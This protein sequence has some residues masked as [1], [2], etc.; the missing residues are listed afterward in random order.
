[1]GN[2]RTLFILY[3]LESA[4]SGL[5]IVFL[6]FSLGITAGAL[7]ANIDR[8]SAFFKRMGIWQK[9]SEGDVL[10]IYQG[11]KDSFVSETA[12][13]TFHI[14]YKNFGRSLF[15]FVTIHA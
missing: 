10:H 7:R 4:Y 15:R 11:Q 8:N 12:F 14:Q 13:L 5:A 9:I 1:M 2:V 6:L 3:S